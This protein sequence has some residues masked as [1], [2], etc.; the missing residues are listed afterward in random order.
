MVRA[1]VAGV[2]NAQYVKFL[3]EFFGKDLVYD[4]EALKVVADRVV[5][6]KRHELFGVSGLTRQWFTDFIRE[7]RLFVSLCFHYK[8]WIQP[9]VCT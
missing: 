3:T 4:A 7:V 5:C 2:T 9:R 6:D 8:T 1:C